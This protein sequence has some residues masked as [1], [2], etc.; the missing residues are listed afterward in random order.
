LT[1]SRFPEVL[2]DEPI[3]RQNTTG[4]PLPT[5]IRTRL[6]RT[7]GQHCDF[8]VTDKMNRTNPNVDAYLSRAKKWQEEL[9]E[10]RT[11]VLDCQLTEELKWGVPC[12][13]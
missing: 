11:I 8:M 12:Y 5:H 3:G 10:L 6:Q 1:A 7:S 9:E 13:T 2:L 4:E